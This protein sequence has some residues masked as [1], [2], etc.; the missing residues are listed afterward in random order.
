[1]EYRDFLNMVKPDLEAMMPGNEVTVRN[2][3]KLQGMSYYGISVRPEGRIAAASLN[4]ES[5]HRRFEEGQ[6]YRQILKGIVNAVRE[7]LALDMHVPL[8]SIKDYDQVKERLTVQLVGREGNE[9]RLLTIPHQDMEDMSLVYHIDLGPMG[10]GTGRILITNEMLQAY[11]ISAERLHQDALKSA[12]ERQPF[13]IRSMNEIM[14]E[15]MGTEPSEVSGAP[16]LY[17]ATNPEM[18]NGACV[19]AYPG[20][21]EAA[22]ETMK[23]NFFILPSSLHEVIMVPENGMMSYQELETIVANVNQTQVLPEDQLSGNV[24]HYDCQEKAFELAAKYDARARRKEEERPSVLKSLEEHKANLSPRK[25][26]P[27]VSRREPA[28]TM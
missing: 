12:Q 4:L 19:I 7:A 9:D 18:K 25:S 5:F 24:Y 26:E 14:A 17:V 21:M 15:F 8:E 3:Q 27:S 6:D 22:A 23:G 1:M 11:G 10:G 28:L 13:V 2:I 20:F 16:D